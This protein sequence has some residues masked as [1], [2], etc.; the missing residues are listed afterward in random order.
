[1]P[2]ITIEYSENLEDLHDITSLVDAVH[3][4]AMDQGIAPL[5]GLRVRA[6]ARKHYKIADGQ[7]SH[8]FVSVIA[9][10]GPGRDD[11]TKTAFLEGLIETVDS[12]LAHLVGKNAVALSAEVQEIDAQFRINRNHVRDALA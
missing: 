3:G 10:I 9:R 8:V 11:A 6:V 5:P 7:S 4:L 12:E 1:M 2:H